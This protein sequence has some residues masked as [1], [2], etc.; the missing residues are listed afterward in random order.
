M[1]RNS[2]NKGID[3]LPANA[4]LI[5]RLHHKPL[6][7]II[8]ELSWTIIGCRIGFDIIEI[9]IIS[10]I[11]GPIDKQHRVQLLVGGPNFTGGPAIPFPDGLLGS[12]RVGCD[13]RGGRF[14][15]F[16]LGLLRL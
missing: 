8:I 5:L 11:I 2:A 16:G 12:P 10:L 15:L 4:I 13:D 6:V 9:A 7:T 3:P 14:Q 1:R